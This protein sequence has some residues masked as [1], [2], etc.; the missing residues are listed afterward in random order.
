MN[1]FKQINNKNEKMADL[2]LQNHFLILVLERFGIGLC[3]KEK[4]I[5]DVFVENNID[6]KVFFTIANLHLNANFLGEYNL[7]ER[8]LITIVN[9]LKES[10]NYYSTEVL[11]Y[12]SQKFN[13]LCKIGDDTTYTLIEKFFNDYKNEVNKHLKYE[14][15]VV[16]PYALDIL[17]FKTNNG[18]YSMQ[19][20]KN[21]HDDIEIKLNDLKNLLIKYIPETG[22]QK[23]IRNILFQLFRFDKDLRIHTVIEEK[24]LIPFIENIEKSSL[25][26]KP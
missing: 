13:E 16:Y 4:T 14:E 25:K 12:I 1:Y 6:L 20:Y 3:L 8:D 7:N 21:H 19:E 9:Y 10:H 11:P 23:L 2:I 26:P 22:K 5:E 24:I 18:N 15:T 17:Q